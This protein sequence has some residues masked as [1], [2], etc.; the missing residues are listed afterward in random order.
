[1]PRCLPQLRLACAG[2]LLTLATALQAAALQVTDD[3]GVTVRWDAPPQRIVS[4]LPS[5]TES[6][7]ELGQCQR[8]IGVDRYSN[9]PAAIDGLPRLG[10]GIDPNLEAIVAMKPDA[11]VM[12]QSSPIVA[13][14]EALGLKVLALEPRS[15][16]DVRRVLAQLARLTGMDEAA[17]QRIWRQIDAAV[18]AAAQSLPP[19]ASR[20]RVYFEA[21]RG[22]YAAGPSSFIGETL[23]RLGVRNVVPPD[24]GPFPKLNPEFVVRANPDLIMIGERNAEGLTQRPGWRGIRAVRE[25]RICV[26][27]EAES[28]VLVRPGPRMAQAA[29][30]MVRCL[31][32]KA[33]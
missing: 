15:H 6:L 21:S 2:L 28:D 33:P 29:R 8:L 19:G 22:Q 23:A 18:S 26:F 1:M 11:V 3:R 5:L 24:Q 25:N 17:A 20:T 14:L 10:G 9:W 7:C 27:T 4:L 16:A 13:R 32:D 30:L 31:Q 12:A